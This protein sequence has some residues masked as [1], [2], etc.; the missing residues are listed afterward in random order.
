MT[1]VDRMAEAIVGALESAARGAA[2]IRTD[3][4]RNRAM[5]ALA[6]RRA[7]PM[8]TEREGLRAGRRGLMTPSS[9]PQGL[10]MRLR[11]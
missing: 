4:E 7:G 1:S 3:R 6:N 9:G 10:S 11:R 8:K 2:T 5:A